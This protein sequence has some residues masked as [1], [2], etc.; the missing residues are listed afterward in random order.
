MTLKFT[1]SE[2]EGLV[3]GWQVKHGPEIAPGTLEAE[4]DDFGQV[5]LA[6]PGSPFSRTHCKKNSAKGRKSLSGKAH[7]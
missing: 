7:E 1:E 5:V 3:L 6:P 4:R 2:P